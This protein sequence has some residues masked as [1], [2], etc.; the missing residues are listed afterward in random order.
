M[1]CKVEISASLLNIK[2]DDNEINAFYRL[3]AAKIDY[4]HID[5]MDG[6]FVQNNTVEMMQKYAD[7][8]KGISNVPLDVHLM[9]EDVKK[10]VDVFAPCMP[11]IINFHIE[12][13]AN[14]CLNIEEKARNFG[15]QN[16]TIDNKIQYVLRSDD[17]IIKNINYIKENECKVGIAINPETD[18][19][20][21]YKYLPYI[22]NVLV[23]SVHPGK[24]GQKF[25]EN[26][27]KKVNKLKDYIKDTNLETEIE[28]DGGI[29]YDTIKLVH[30]ADIVAVGKFLIDAKDYKFTVNALKNS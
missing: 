23:M 20:E 8:I 25:I 14:S 13:T 1:I 3:E 11:N 28:V 12:K 10:Y 7:N 15:E 22:H 18:I 17:E 19:E 24:G 26:T 4:F 21:V 2:E 9:V 5:V 16:D 27:E 6:M 30:N 29:N